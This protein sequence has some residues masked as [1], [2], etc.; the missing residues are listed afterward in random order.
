M[1]KLKALITEAVVDTPEF[2]RWFKNSKIS[3]NGVPIV[4][5]HGTNANISKFDLTKTL[6]GVF[7]FT[8]NK[9]RSDMYSVGEGGNVMPVYLSIQNPAPL[10]HWNDVQK[11][12]SAGKRGDRSA[13]ILVLAKEFLK[14]EGY[15]GVMG[16]L[17]GMG[18]KEI[19]ILAFEPNQIKSAIGN[20]GAFNPEDDDVTKENF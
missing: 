15:D 8:N 11:K 14:K 18:G 16:Q 5:Y 13:N 19:V 9:G 7:Y 4:V 3:D 20:R 17:D 10:T 6:K 12:I 1:I 2:K